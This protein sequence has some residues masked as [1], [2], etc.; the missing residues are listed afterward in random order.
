MENSQEKITISADE[1]E[2]F[3]EFKR[4]K[5][6]DEVQRKKDGDRKAYKVLINEMVNEHF[7]HLQAISAQLAERK[8]AVYDT[9]DQALDTKVELYEVKSDQRT[10]TFIN[11]EQNRRIMLGH[12][13]VDAWDDTAAE[14]E[15][16]IKDYMASLADSKKSAALIK[17]IMKFLAK[18]KAGNL[19]L[20]GVLQLR[21][22]AIELESDLL[23]N[24]VK[25][26]YDA[27][28]P[29]AS[30]TFVR[31]EFKNEMGAWVNVP[32]GMTEV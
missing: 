22:L 6:A 7:P 17:T 21:E 2:Q 27:Y 30:K 29:A 31:A 32:L 20:S 18:D 15:T 14:G 28:R 24:G 13:Q 12:H 10:H 25:V 11:A 16:M 5:E 3:A 8:K 1:A 26:V 9:F 23:S 19:R 4:K